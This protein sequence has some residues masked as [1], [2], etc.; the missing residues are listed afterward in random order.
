MDQLPFWKKDEFSIAEIEEFRRTP[1][2]LVFEKSLVTQPHGTD[3][4]LSDPHLQKCLIQKT[5]WVAESPRLFDILAH[6]IQSFGQSVRYLT[7]SFGGDEFP[8]ARVIDVLPDTFPI[9]QILHVESA[10]HI[11]LTNLPRTLRKLTLTE[12]LIPNCH[13]KNDLPILDEFKYSTNDNHLT[14]DPGPRILQRILPFSSKTTIDCLHVDFRMQWEPTNDAVQ[15]FSLIHQFG[16]ITNLNVGTASAQMFC[17]L[18]RSSFRLKSFQAIAATD[19]GGPD[20][21][22]LQS[23]LHLV[24]SPVLH[25]VEDLN[26]EYIQHGCNT[27]YSGRS[28]EPLIRTIANLQALKSLQLFCPLNPDWFVHFHNAHRLKRVLWSYF[29][30]VGGP[31]I[32]EYDLAV[33]ARILAT[34]M[35]GNYN[36]DVEIKISCLDPMT[37]EEAFERYG[38]GSEDSEEDFDEEFDDDEE[39]EDDESEDYESDHCET[40]NEDVEDDA[41]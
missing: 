14:E 8:W 29:R 37:P 41:G 9:L 32:D 35:S 40:D 11:H 1:R 5:G 27:I 19:V 33:L 4:L 6:N 25:N 31:P 34:V 20:L 23:F 39:N 16:N 7:L 24:K 2:T 15:K 13:C 10:D 17:F 21:D 12:P 28:F 22:A 30:F 36:R 26:Y 3:V 18:A 38:P